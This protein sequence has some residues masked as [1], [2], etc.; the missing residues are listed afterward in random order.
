MAAVISHKHRTIFVHIPKTAG[1]SVESVY[2]EDLGLTW[3]ERERLALA[4]ND[5]RRLGPSRL[6]HLYADEYVAMGHISQSDYDSYFKFAVVRNPYDK[7]LSAYRYLD[8]KA[9]LPLWLWLLWPVGDDFHSPN[10]HRVSQRRFLYDRDG[11]LLVDR[12]VRFENLS[13]EMPEVIEQT[14]GSRRDLPRRNVTKKRSNI[15]RN[16]LNALHRFIIRLRYAE[17]FETFGYDPTK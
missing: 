7:L 11:K 2:L 1:Q 14:I 13:V 5:D 16:G 8:H 10:R 15:A 3:D 4:W 6:A 9:R 12:V 17:D